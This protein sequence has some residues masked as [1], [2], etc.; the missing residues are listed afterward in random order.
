P[1]PKPLWR[2]YEPSAPSEPP[3]ARRRPAPALAANGD[4]DGKAISN[5]DTG[6]GK[7]KPGS[8]PAK[9]M[10]VA[11]GAAKLNPN[12]LNPHRDAVADHFATPP[13]DP[14]PQR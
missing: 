13:P 12:V 10:A 2:P 5:S 14:D 9:T 6:K 8:V 3:P 4:G 7:E 11:W 1:P